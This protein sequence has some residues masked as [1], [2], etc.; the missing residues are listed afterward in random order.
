MYIT[1]YDIRMFYEL[2]SRYNT[3]SPNIAVVGDGHKFEKIVKE[4]LK[5]CKSKSI[6][7]IKGLN[8]LRIITAD[9]IEICYIRVETLNDLQGRYFKKFI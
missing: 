6:R 8:T 2:H 5:T 9:D 4:V 7:V 3:A 1:E